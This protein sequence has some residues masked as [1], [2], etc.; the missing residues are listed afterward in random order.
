MGVDR[1][2]LHICV[3]LS[4][5]TVAT[6]DDQHECVQK[7]KLLD[8]W[9][10]GF[11]KTLHNRSDGKEAGL[12]RRKRSPVVVRCLCGL[13][14][15]R[16]TSFFLICV[17]LAGYLFRHCRCFFFAAIF[18][19]RTVTNSS[20][21]SSPIGSSAPLHPALVPVIVVGFVLTAIVCVALLIFR[22]KKVREE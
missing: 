18:A 14:S 3:F 19:V 16:S 20:S 10:V 6:T 8:D 9:S 15:S 4:F 22:R 13:S 21:I 2:R 7:E 11:C 17:Y 12:R 1:V 5:R